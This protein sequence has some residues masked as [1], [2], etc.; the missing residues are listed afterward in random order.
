M[1]FSH[2]GHRRLFRDFSELESGVSCGPGSALAL[3]IQYFF[4]S[5]ANSKR[6]RSL[7]QAACRLTL[8][9]LKYFDHYLARKPGAID[10]ALGFFF[11]G[12]KSREP[13]SDRELVKLY[14]GNATDMF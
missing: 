12:R 7:I 4:F 9:W 8:F 14:R 3:S 1:R 10:A 11:V 13:L 2:I 5:F 6:T